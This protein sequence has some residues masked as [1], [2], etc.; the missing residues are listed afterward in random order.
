MR[1]NEGM[2]GFRHVEVKTG[3]A[4]RY[5]FSI[6]NHPLVRRNE[7]AFAMPQRKWAA[8]SLDQDVFVAPFQYDPSTQYIGAITLDADFQTK[9]K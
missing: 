1:E 8:L 4:H 6:K 9:K 7:I 3:P 5:V 2:N